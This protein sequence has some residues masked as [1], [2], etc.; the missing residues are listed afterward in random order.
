[1]PTVTDVKQKKARK[2]DAN[3]LVGRDENLRYD[4]VPSA[5]LPPTEMP[6]DESSRRKPHQIVAMF[7][8]ESPTSTVGEF[9]ARTAEIL[10][11]RGVE[12]HIFSRHPFFD[13]DSKLAKGH[14]VGAC[15]GDDLVA[16]VNEFTR[17]ACNS[18]LRT[19]RAPASRITLMGHEWSTIPAI[20]LLHGIKN[21]DTVLSVQSIERQRGGLDTGVG[22]WI[23]ETELAG[24]REAKSIIVHDGGTGDIIANC[25]PDKAKHIVNVSMDIPMAGFEFDLDPGEVKERFDVGPIDPTILFIGDLSERYGANLLMKAMP[26]VLKKQPQARC[27]FVGD[28]DL[29]WPLRVYSRYLLLDHAV[30]LAGHVGDKPLFEL[31]HSA[32]IV[33]VPSLEET[34]WW[35]IEAAWVAKRPVVATSEA[36]PSL[37]EHERNC[38]IINPNEKDLASGIWRVLE[39]R[40]F[41]QDIA[42]RG[43][44]QIGQRYNENK[45]VAQLEQAID[46]GIL[47]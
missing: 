8:Y 10:A 30:R 7:C 28:G 5:P 1:M 16:Q 47:A 36:A 44:N 39:D 41:A 9:V 17:R 15:D 21:L 24:L 2:R 37:L 6:R 20:S 12:V 23:E 45:I 18:F 14:P 33:V 27:I 35:P 26:A 34:P 46:I 31:I 11:T 25:F 13:V 22:K 43:N 32:D 29:L 42:R 40:T 3:R 19:F 38:T 4:H